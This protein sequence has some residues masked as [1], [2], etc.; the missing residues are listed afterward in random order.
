MK[1]DK[2]ALINF[3][4]F[5]QNVGGFHNFLLSTNANMLG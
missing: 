1:N 5:Y 4:V 3:K 2:N